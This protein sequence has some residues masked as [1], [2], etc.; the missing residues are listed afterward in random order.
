MWHNNNGNAI[1]VNTIP[2][3]YI[4]Y[5]HIFH[6]CIPCGTTWKHYGCKC[7]STIIN[8]AYVWF[9]NCIA[10]GTTIIAITSTMVIPEC[11]KSATMHAYVNWHD[12]TI[13]IESV[14]I[15]LSLP[16]S[17]YLYTYIYRIP[18][19]Q[20]GWNRGRQ[21]VEGAV[22]SDDWGG[23]SHGREKAQDSYHQVQVLQWEQLYWGSSASSPSF[24]F[25]FGR[26]I[27]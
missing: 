3:S 23:G 5:R 7:N 16:L 15:E 11:V 8:M 20:R 19:G 18:E 25:Y 21:R 22:S 10:C 17:T 27:V 12:S 26:R 1:D 14:S 13:M 2:P 4:Q 24:D 9:E 6:N